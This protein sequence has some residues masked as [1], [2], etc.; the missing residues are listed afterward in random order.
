MPSK[1]QGIQTESAPKAVGPYS[2]G[3]KVPKGAELV[4]VSG[5]IPLDPET[6]K[7]VEADIRR[8][9]HRVIDSIEGIL[10]EGDATL[11][12]VIRVEI[13]LTD[14]ND[15][16][17]VNEEYAKRFVGNPLPAR[18]AVQVAAL[19]L[20]VRIEMSCVAIIST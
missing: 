14:M 11:S 8:L 16:A 20:G 12:D 17:A 19:P 1:L 7:L 4:F 15:F 9:T 10:K 3:I 6:G 5:Q 13:F 18:Q 2:Q